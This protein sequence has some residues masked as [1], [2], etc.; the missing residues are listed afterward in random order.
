MSCHKEQIYQKYG[1]VAHNT[2]PQVMKKKIEEELLSLAHQILQMSGRGDVEKL[3]QASRQVYEKLAL[4]R[5]VDH[6]FSDVKPTISKEDAMVYLEEV[7]QTTKGKVD[8]QANIEERLRELIP[9]QNPHENDLIEPLME[10]IKD[11]VA[12]MP[13]ESSAVDD[14]F[15]PA[16]NR[17]ESLSFDFEEVAKD[18]QN[19][20]TFEEVKKP[21]DVKTDVRP[22]SLNDSFN[23]GIQF[24]LNDKLA[25]INHLFDGE[26]ENFNRV[27]SQLNTFS[28][29]EETM[30][31]INEVVKPDY[32]QWEGKESLED[33]FIQIINARF[34]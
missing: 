16:P 11:M 25:F 3:Y 15:E 23:K 1:A 26:A 13:S 2:F 28:D 10:T 20:P 32:N 5:F 14:L 24:G 7:F 33:R 6:H 17:R 19:L 21:S 31:F 9:D 27:V 12:Q 34:N 18:Y 8:D 4:M 30:N 29:A 22:K